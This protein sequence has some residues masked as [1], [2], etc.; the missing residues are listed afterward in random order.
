MPRKLKNLI[1]HTFGKLTVVK[2]AGLKPAGKQKQ[3]AWL[4][5]CECGTIVEVLNNNLK[6]GNT[7]S[8]GCHHKKRAKEANL[9]DISG[10]KYGLLQALEYVESR[11]RN[12]YWKCICEC[13]KETIVSSCGL[14]SGGV[15]S[16]GCRQGN[17]IHGE[18]SKGRANYSRYRRQDPLVRLRHNVSAAIRDSLK[19]KSN[20]SIFDY[21]PYTFQELKEHLESQFESWMTWDNYGG[22]SN[23][24]RKT[25]HMDHIQPQCKFSYQSLDDPLM[26]E[27]WALSNLQPLEKKTNFSKG[28]K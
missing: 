3:S 9:I 15:K 13:G 27:C 24:E 19:Y 22:K 25:W 20:K 21:L 5:K 12:A 17:F 1:G 26:V 11:N 28:A 18:W 6:K 10:K 8:C 23:D 7:K 14:K 16:C 2:Y 4:C